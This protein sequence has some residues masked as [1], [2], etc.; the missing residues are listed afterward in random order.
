[1]NL[2][3]RDRKLAELGFSTYAEYLE[4]PHWKSLRALYFKKVQPPEVCNRCR[5]LFWASELVYGS[6]LNLHHKTYERLGAEEFS[7]LEPVCRRCHELEHF[8]KS[9]LPKI[10]LR[11]CHSCT[12]P[13][14]TF[15]PPMALEDFTSSPTFGPELAGDVIARMF[16][17]KDKLRVGF[18]RKAKLKEIMEHPFCRVK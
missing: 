8:G 7:D 1:M 3:E 15:D 18:K 9:D 13:R 17:N 5:V 10:V 2:A 4:S 14:I 11:A 12:R 6:Q 16:G